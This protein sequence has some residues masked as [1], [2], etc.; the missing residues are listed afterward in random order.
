MNLRLLSRPKQAQE[1]V[2]I[3]HVY[4]DV[5][6]I[7]APPGPTPSPPT[8][9]T[10]N[11]PLPASL[12]SLLSGGGNPSNAIST[13]LSTLALNT[14]TPATRNLTSD[15]NMSPGFPQSVPEKSHL[16]EAPANSVDTQPPMDPAHHMGGTNPIGNVTMA[17]LTRYIDER[18]A[19]H[20]EAITRH[21]DDA[22][23]RIIHALD[24]NTR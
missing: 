15:C 16:D 11:T 2:R 14:S 18:L 24:R 19:Q 10:T 7:R 22:V 4:L 6:A 21:I 5:T 3:A 9:F 17:Q 13:L 12:A 1:E 23:T 8:S 20:Q